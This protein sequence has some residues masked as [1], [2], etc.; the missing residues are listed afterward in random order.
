MAYI[1]STV[2][3]RKDTKHRFPAHTAV[4]AK[5][6]SCPKLK[7][8]QHGS[9]LSY[10]KP[11]IVQMLV[12]FPQH[13]HPYVA[14]PQKRLSNAGKQD[15]SRST[16]TRDSSHNPS[17]TKRLCHQPSAQGTITRCA[18]LCLTLHYATRCYCSFVGSEEP[19]NLSNVGTNLYF[20]RQSRAVQIFRDK[21]PR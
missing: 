15:N 13:H 5:E 10:E 18:F 21:S 2:G 12:Y 9:S 16:I 8:R 19:G 11:A 4:H 14:L 3:P 7:S 17:R 1:C 6:E 20:C